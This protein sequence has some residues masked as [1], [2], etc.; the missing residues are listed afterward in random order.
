MFRLILSTLLIFMLFFPPSMIL[1]A[2]EE[3]EAAE[4]SEENKEPVLYYEIH[5]NILT[6][7][8]NT[9]R[10]IGYIVVQVQVVVRGQ[11]NYDLIEF[12]LPLLQDALTDFFN[13]QDKA[14]IHD[15]QQRGMLRTQAKE[16]ISQVLEEEIGEKIVED[17][18]FT[19]YVY[20]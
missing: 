13:R 8:Q 9:G 2:A 5:P 14:V 3:T 1:Q 4:K 17:V 20:Q 18:L 16:R 15:L 10:K 6:F 19:Q 12:H 11:E 7:Y